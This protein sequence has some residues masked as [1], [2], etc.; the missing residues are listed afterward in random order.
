[1]EDRISELSV[2]RQ[3]EVQEQLDKLQASFNSLKVQLAKLKKEKLPSKFEQPQ[4]Y[5]NVD[6]VDTLSKASSYLTVLNFVK[7]TSDQI[8]AN[9]E[10]GRFG[11]ANVFLINNSFTCYFRIFNRVGNGSH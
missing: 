8:D 1:M 6:T 5:E 3:Q 11:F 9:L 4:V 10:N 2:H 7:A